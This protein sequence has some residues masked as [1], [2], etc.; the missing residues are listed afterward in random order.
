M[1]TADT[2]GDGVID[3]GEFVAAYDTIG[4]GA[5]SRGVQFTWLRGG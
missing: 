3:Y 1:V 5:P 4:E 2:N